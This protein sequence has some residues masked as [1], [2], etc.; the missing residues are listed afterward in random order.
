VPG[1]EVAVRV[2]AELAEDPGREDRA[3]PG[4]A[5]V[6]LSVPVAAKMRAHHLAE[7]VNLGVEVSMTATSLVTM[8]A[9][10]AWITVGWRRG[11]ARSTASSA[12]ALS[13][14]SRRLAAAARS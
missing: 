9:S 1:V 8:A 2:V 3:E 7:L 11:S 10:A 14:V 6:D 13:W 4:L 12:V 5:G